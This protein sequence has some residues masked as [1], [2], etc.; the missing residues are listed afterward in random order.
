M[1]TPGTHV[2]GAVRQCG[3]TGQSG[4]YWVLPG[5]MLLTGMLVNSADQMSVQAKQPLYVRQNGFTA[6]KVILTLTREKTPPGHTQR[7]HSLRF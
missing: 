3:Q 5:D 2:N 7:I 4:V 6:R 1:Y